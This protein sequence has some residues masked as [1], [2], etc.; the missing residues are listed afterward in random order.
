MI[1]FSVFSFKADFECSLG[2]RN[3]SLGIMVGVCGFYFY[4]RRMVSQEIYVNIEIIICP[5]METQAES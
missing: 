3:H 4:Y 1:N 2:I 5:L